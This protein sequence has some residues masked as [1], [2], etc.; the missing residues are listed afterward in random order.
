MNAIWGLMLALGLVACGGGGGGGGGGGNTSA[1]S[2][3][4]SILTGNVQVGHSTSLT[5]RATARDP[6]QF[7][8]QL[9]VFIVDPNHVITSTVSL[10]AVDSTTMSATVYTSPNLAAGHYQGSWQVQ[11]CKDSGCA[12]QI[13]GSPVALPYDIT[14]ANAPLQA[15]A[16]TTTTLTSHQGGNLA[17]SVSIGVSG[18]GSSWTAAADAAWLQLSATSGTGNSLTVSYATQALALGS[19][20][21]NVLVTSSDGQKATVPFSLTV[22]APGFLISSGVPSFA[23]VNGAPIPAQT[24]AFAIDNGVP[25]AWQGSV[26]APWMSMS[27]L[28]GTTPAS[29]TLQPNPSVGSLASGSY[30]AD[31]TLTA[32]GLANKTVTS[33]LTLTAPTLSAPANSVTLGGTYGRDLT[34]AQ[35]LNV[36]LNTGSNGWPYTLT[37]LPSWLSSTT[38]SGTVS[39][40][41]TPVTVKPLVGAV[42]AGSYSAVVNVTAKINGDTTTL[43]ITVN[44]NADQRKLLASMWSVGFASSPTGSVLSRTLTIADNYGGAVDW[45]AASDASWLAVTGSGTTGG[46]STLTLS[47]NPASL[48]AET[49][50]YATVTVSPGTGSQITPARIRVAIWKS[51]SGLTSIAKVAQGYTWIIAD[52]M[53]PYA[54][55]HSG[56]ST[57]DVYNAYT[58]QKIGSFNNVAASLGAMGLSHDGSKL[59]ALDRANKQMAVIDLDAGTAGT[60]W[61]LD[62]AVDQGT[63]LV[64][65]RANG[66]DFVL[67]SDGTAYRQAQSLGN[68]GVAGAQVATID[69]SRVYG[70]NPITTMDYSQMSGGVLL[71][72]TGAYV[73]YSYR[74][75]TSY[76]TISPD[77]SRVYSANGGGTQNGY[78]CGVNDGATGSYIGDLPGGS[79][80]PNNVAVAID[81]RVL[82]GAQSSNGTYDFWLHAANGAFLRGYK[83]SGQGLKGGQTAFTADGL[84]V[85]ALT[86]DPLLA[87]VPVGP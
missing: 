6:S 85:V 74:G 80:Y 16:A 65:V 82:C 63:A 21:G 28:S 56:G 18:G 15:T 64:P 33:K 66:E 84:V 5:V 76:M 87:F 44:L 68:S 77:G 29:V 10:A 31:V 72:K 2:F 36:S 12:T 41:G 52:R 3:N 70:W 19:Y 55:A 30:S 83:F 20:A 67:L 49:V 43:P 11:L 39:Q 14:V 22:L 73:S 47:A 42:S 38:M 69:G 34:T 60:L 35:S 40:A 32:T 58:A 62:N 24:L 7:S 27:V 75:G 50:S 37:G 46:T 48:P 45:T 1:V 4:P 8:G 9:Y 23:A 51:A 78:F 71:K 54:Y 81:G 26:S 17:G 25:M 86:D 79:A 13:P 53:R 61:K 59:Y 57:I